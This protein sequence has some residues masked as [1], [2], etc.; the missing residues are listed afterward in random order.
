MAIIMTMKTVI[1]Y[2][3][4]NLFAKKQKIRELDKQNKIFEK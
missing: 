1:F 3:I 2:F 4:Q